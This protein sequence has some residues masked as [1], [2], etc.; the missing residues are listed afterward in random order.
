MK[1]ITVIIA[2]ALFLSTGCADRTIKITKDSVTFRSKLFGNKNEIGPIEVR[3]GTNV[4]K[5]E[6]FKSDQVQ[7]LESVTR[8]AVE[9]A[10]KSM[11]P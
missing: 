7:A 10:V 3:L 8:A 11:K 1:K 4:L 6:S 9:S 5:I 2:S